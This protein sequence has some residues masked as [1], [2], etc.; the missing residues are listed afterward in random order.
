M[1]E[2]ERR[3][4]IMEAVERL[5]ARGGINAVTMRA[6]AAEADVSLRL[7]QYYGNTKD[8]LLS[9][10]LERLAEKSVQRWRARV[11]HEGSK[12]P[13]DVI[14][15]FFDEALPTDTVSEDFHRLGVSL[16][17]L[18]ISDPGVAGQAYQSHLSGLADELADI[19]RPD[20]TATIA[21]RLALEVMGLAH[22]VASLLM[23]RQL[24][25]RD[26]L[27]LIKSYLARLEPLLST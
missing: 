13:L 26:A 1:S 10:T 11:Q 23:A 2:Q 12:A 24:S 20:L 4:Q 16:E 17:A 7:V 27:A 5:L 25:E 19:L 9:A 15:L 6:V 21:R 14:K 18:S 8:E 22:G 3:A